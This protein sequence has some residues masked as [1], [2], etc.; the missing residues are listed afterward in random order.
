MDLFSDPY[1]EETVRV[2]EVHYPGGETE[3]VCLRL[4]DTIEVTDTALVVTLLAEAPGQLRF[5]LAPLL[6]YSLRTQT[7]KKK[8]ARPVG[9]AAGVAV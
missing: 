7:V 5:N 4:G 3:Q 6:W 2:L 1:V 9:A 8:A